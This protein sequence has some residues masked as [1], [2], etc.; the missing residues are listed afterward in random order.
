MEI[1]DSKVKSS[2][3]R[4]QIIWLHFA[5]L[6]GGA[7]F[8]FEFCLQ[9]T[10]AQR[11]T[12]SHASESI[13]KKVRSASRRE[14]MLGLRISPHKLMKMRSVLKFPG[15]FYGDCVFW[16]GEREGRPREDHQLHGGGTIYAASIEIPK[17]NS[18]FWFYEC[19]NVFWSENLVLL[20][21]HSLS[22][23]SSGLTNASLIATK[24]AIYLTQE[25]TCNRLSCNIIHHNYIEWGSEL[26]I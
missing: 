24:P 22:W 2:C 18:R 19:W 8:N 5:E 17:K 4:F 1:T 16:K 25:K 6:I 10:F 12:E 3:Q 9:F 20:L 13:C 7:G 21:W 15:C 11:S 23:G 26:C 14:Y